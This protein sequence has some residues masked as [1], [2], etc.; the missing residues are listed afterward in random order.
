MNLEELTAQAEAAHEAYQRDHAQ[1]FRDAEGKE[2][3]FSDAEHGERVHTLQRERSQKIDTV[4]AEIRG[5]TDGAHKELAL[6][7]NEDPTA[8]LTTDEFAAAT[9]KKSFTDDV[10]WSAPKDQLVSKLKA[11]LAGG[12]RSSIFAYWRAGVSRYGALESEGGSASTGSAALGPQD[13]AK[14]LERC[15]ASWPAPSALRRLRRLAS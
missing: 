6:A 5:L 14:V 15:A 3:L 1:L 12:D 13:L 2:K 8:V 7:E 9:A 10:V 11:V 4:I